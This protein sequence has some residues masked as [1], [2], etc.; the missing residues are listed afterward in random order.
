MRKN[1]RTSY[2]DQF[3]NFSPSGFLVGPNYEGLDTPL[4]CD[5]RIICLNYVLNQDTITTADLILNPHD[6]L[7]LYHFLSSPS[8]L[9]APDR[10]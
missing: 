8:D 7:L 6:S 10:W 1:Y 5:I 3:S 4:L 9:C 2:Q